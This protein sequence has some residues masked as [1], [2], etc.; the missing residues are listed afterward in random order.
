MRLFIAFQ[1]SE[2]MKRALVSVRNALKKGGAR[3]T[4]TKTENL[5]LTLAFIG[6]YPDPDRVLDAMETV[7][8]R[9][10][11][12]CLDGLGS[13]GDLYWCGLGDGAAGRRRLP[14]GGSAVGGG[15][16]ADGGELAACAA[17]LR[18]ALAQENIPFDRKRFTPHITLL[19]RGEFARGVPGI[20]VPEASMEADAMSLMRSDRGRNGMIYTELGRVPAER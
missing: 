14:E 11:P 15:G 12:L 10:V 9:P 3:G 7:P 4:F 5:H 1:L 18:R 2:D 6:E 19:R 16:T 20:A 17:R 13:F 8:F